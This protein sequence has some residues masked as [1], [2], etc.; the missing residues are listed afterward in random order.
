MSI[1]FDPMEINGMVAPN[2]FVRSATNDRC[3][4]ASGH[5]S[6]MLIA[7]YEGLARGGVGLII[8][9]NAYVKGNGRTSPTMMGAQDDGFLPGLRRLAEAVHRYDSK[10]V[11]Q[12]SHAGRQA[13]SSVLHESPVAPSAVYYRLSK[14][15]PRAMTEDEIEEVIDAYAAASRRAAAAGFDGVQFHGAHG[16]LISQFMSPYT[17]KREDRWGGSLENRMRFPL[18]VYRRARKAVGDGY[19]VIIKLNSE[20]F[21]EGGLTLEEGV[22]IAGALAREGIDAIEISGGM[23]ESGKHISMPGI[24]TEEDE[25]YYLANARRFREAMDVPLILVG[26]LRTPALMERLLEKGEA[27]MVSLCRPFIREP[28]LVNQWKRG[29]RKKA[30]CISCNGCLKFRDQAVRCTQLD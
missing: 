11:L 21:L 22:Q 26:G 28:D 20:D 10:I 15:T 1:L 29:D 19:P 25:A 8:I 14:E 13:S 3:A 16:Y 17:N 18:E 27:D 5:V 6:D 2:R 4:D 12:I 23:V 9:G 24:K 30:D 7:I